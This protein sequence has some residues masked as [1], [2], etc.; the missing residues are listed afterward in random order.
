MSLGT[1]RGVEPK[2][3]QE[4]GEP[5]PGLIVGQSGRWQFEYDVTQVPETSSQ[6]KH[7][8]TGTFMGLS[9]CGK[10]GAR[11]LAFVPGSELAFGVE[12]A[13]I[14]RLSALGV[15]PTLLAI[16]QHSFEDLAGV[17]PTIIEEDAGDVL[18]ELLGNASACDQKLPILHRPGTPERAL[19]NQKILYDVFV[20]M[21]NAHRA[22]IY[23]Q[24]LR[25]ENVCVRRFGAAP[26]DIRATVIDF[27]LGMDLGAG[28]RGARDPFFET[29]LRRRIFAEVPSRL[30]G[31]DVSVDPNPL[32]RDMGYLA[33]LQYH[34]ERD[35][36]I[37]NSDVLTDGQLRDFAQYLSGH[38]GYFW[39]QEDGRPLA[40]QLDEKLDVEGLANDLHLVRVDEDAFPSAQLLAHAL[41]L[42]RP[43]LDAED[44]EICMRGPEARLAKSIDTIVAQKYET[45]KAR[46][47][48]EG[49]E[50]Y[51]RYEDQ[52]IDL[53]RSNY[54]QAEHIPVKV[55]TLG[56]LLVWEDD[57][58]SL[59]ASFE[60]VT[61]FTDEQIEM[62]ARLEHDRWMDERRALGWTLDR[63]LKDR[64]VERKATPHLIPYDEMSE[65][66]KEYDRDVARGLIPLVKSV[67]LM[68]VRPK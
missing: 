30:T 65:G 32:E 33:V 38:V 50:V 42:H 60:E 63:T 66:M 2:R 26:A 48:A 43:Y 20:Q 28:E 47:R 56:Y 41:T 55:R 14:S 40:R 7:I 62:L 22:G 34:V 16:T 68:V 18:S 31:T 37:F 24:D 58:A 15:G 23:H 36:L 6:R 35:S 19:E 53:Q 39:Y 12:C 9:Q 11:A 67:G 1:T 54:A 46:R 4:L 27:D 17:C 52:P 3:L 5:K 29:Q 44:W 13:N 51:E 8:Y 49:K 45:Y 25:C 64:D 59:E 10:L 21:M 61:S 57:R